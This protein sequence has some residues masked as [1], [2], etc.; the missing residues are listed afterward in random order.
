METMIEKFKKGTQYV[1]IT[2][3]VTAKHLT[4]IN[5]VDDAYLDQKCLKFIPASGA[6]S[7]MFKDLYQY[8]EDQIETDF[9]KTFFEKLECFAFFNDLKPFIEKNLADKGTQAGKAAIIK[10]LL[11]G[12]LNYGNLPKALLKVHSYGQNSVTPIDEH[13]YEGR[14]YAGRDSVKLHFT[15]SQEHEDLFNE[16]VQKALVATKGVDITYSFQKKSTDTI[17]VDKDNQPFL[18]ENGQILY[19]AGGHGALIENLND[20]DDEIIFI[21]NIDNVCHRDHVATTVESKK[22]LASTGFVVKKRIDGYIRDLLAGKGD[23]EEIKAFIENTLNITCKKELTVD[24]ALSFLNRPL[25]VCGVV[26]NQGEPGGGPFIVDSG[27]YQDLQICEMSEIDLNNAD[28]KALV[29]KSQ[30]FNPVDL[31]CFIR[32]YQGDKFDLLKFTNPDRYFISEKSYQGR[33]LKALEHPGLWNGAMHNWNTLFVEVP[34]ATFNPIKTVNDLL[35][36]GHQK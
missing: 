31:V 20:L 22:M 24:T 19:R 27:D 12:G 14:Q 32:D 30:F 29:S 36:K 15:I 23:F 3:V 17:A 8:L 1:N 10:S 9:I 4:S 18:D 25:R 13:I 5:Q 35:R 7:R 21:K 33:Q 6:A 11:S 2:G 34:L 28:K 26:K 16:Y